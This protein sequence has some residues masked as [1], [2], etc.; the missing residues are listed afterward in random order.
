MFSLRSP[1]SNTSLGVVL[2]M[3]EPIYLG[4][5]GT[6]SRLVKNSK[7]GTVRAAESHEFP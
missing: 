3:C 5:S 6:A 2:A 1:G 7:Q 4:D